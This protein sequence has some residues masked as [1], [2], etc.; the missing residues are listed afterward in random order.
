MKS[1]LE[2]WRVEMNAQYATENK[3]FDKKLQRKKKKN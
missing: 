2:E 3:N 1:K